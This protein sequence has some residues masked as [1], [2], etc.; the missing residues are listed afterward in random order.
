MGASILTRGGESATRGQIPPID[1]AAHPAYGGM[2]PPRPALRAETEPTLR[3]LIAEVEEED[4]IRDAAFGYR[5]GSGTDISREV[6]A[7]GWCARQL[8]PARLE[9]LRRSAWPIV[10][11]IRA[12]LAK[13][14]ASGAAI[15]FKA[16]Q[17]IIGK[18]SHRDLWIQ[19]SKAI[20]EAGLV[21]A[22]SDY[23]GASHAA[24]KSAAVMVNQPGQAWCNDVFRD[25]AIETPPTVGLHIDS[26]S[27]CVMKVVLYLDDVGPDQGPF[28]VV[29]TS[30]L[31]DQGGV[32]RVRRRA[33]DRS[34]FV[35][36]ARRQRQAFLSLPPEFQ[37]KAEFGSD[38]LPGALETLE[39]L[40]QEEIATGPGGQLNIFDPEAV[41]RGGHARAG[42]RLVMLLSIAAKFWDLA[43]AD[44]KT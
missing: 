35:S 23:F 19:A 25:A 3:R 40:A 18:D 4:R 5:Y 41:H 9:L 17:E 39:I 6:A 37:L 33:F 8:E 29:P 30:H 44:P 36:R 42:E 15:G 27:L 34:P 21:A 26:V 43:A 28:G 2:F 11:E 32:G 10:E 24:L 7:R 13:M 12:R 31:W 14:R 1:Y 20:R 16:T 38:M 22:A